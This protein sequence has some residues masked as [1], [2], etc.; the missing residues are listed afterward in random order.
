MIG[1]GQQTPFDVMFA[2]AQ[3]EPFRAGI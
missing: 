3:Q 1:T 2:A